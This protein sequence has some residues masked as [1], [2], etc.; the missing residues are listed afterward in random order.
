[1]KA[2]ISCLLLGGVFVFFLPFAAVAQMECSG[3]LAQK[4]FGKE[5]KDLNVKLQKNIIEGRKLESEIP[6]QASGGADQ[7]G[8]QKR[9]AEIMA[10]IQEQKKT[11]E[12]LNSPLFPQTSLTALGAA[13]TDKRWIDRAKEVLLKNPDK[14]GGSYFVWFDKDTREVKASRQRP[15]FNTVAR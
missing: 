13:C 3:A 2:T 14:L 8:S 5:I 9:L 7:I 11:F 4:H 10:E 15:N 6:Q 1:M 12:L